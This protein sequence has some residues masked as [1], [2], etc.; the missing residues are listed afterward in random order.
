MM[1][2]VIKGVILIDIICKSNAQ[3]TE[4]VWYRLKCLLFNVEKSNLES[5]CF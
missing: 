1:L 4:H 2:L 3:M 5:D